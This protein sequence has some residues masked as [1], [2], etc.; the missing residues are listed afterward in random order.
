LVLSPLHVFVGVGRVSF[1]NSICLLQ[2]KFEGE[3][4]FIF[5]SVCFLM[6]LFLVLM[7]MFLFR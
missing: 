5:S 3:F 4:V 7:F 6:T 2:A 1:P